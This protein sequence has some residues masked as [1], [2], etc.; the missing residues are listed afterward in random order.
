MNARTAAKA[1]LLLAAGPLLA[2]SLNACSFSASAGTSTHDFS[3]T[4]L[5]GN[6]QK[7]LVAQNPDLEITGTT[8]ADTP[9]IA[10]GKT[11]DC[12]A[13]VNGTATKFVVTW[14][15]SDGNYEVNSVEA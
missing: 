4:K 15:D 2:L 10:A 14:K 8:C 7:Q 11:T 5:A 3:G 12:N 6:V 13:S 1:A 9:E